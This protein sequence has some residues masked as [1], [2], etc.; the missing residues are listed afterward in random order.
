M[1][2]VHSERDAFSLTDKQEYYNCLIDPSENIETFKFIMN[3]WSGIYS[4]DFL[5]KYHIRHNETPGASYQDQW[6]L[7]PDILPCEESMVC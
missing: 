5:N 7:V 1:K 2:T 4:L 3:T 6:F